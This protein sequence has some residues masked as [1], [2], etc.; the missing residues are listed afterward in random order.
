M[1]DLGTTHPIKGD[2]SKQNPSTSRTASSS[3]L[4]V[5]KSEHHLFDAYPLSHHCNEQ[6][7]AKT[8]A[9]YST[10]HDPVP[11]STLDT[12]W[13]WEVGQSILY[14]HW[15][16]T[17]L[18]DIGEDVDG[19]YNGAAKPIERHRNDVPTKT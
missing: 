13:P 8:H 19:D 18:E 4:I 9:Q 15:M 1:F 2:V 17:T 16:K 5:S 11:N 6:D 3:S 10:T 12:N 14:H 7:D